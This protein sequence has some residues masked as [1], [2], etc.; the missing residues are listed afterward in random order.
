M[1]KWEGQTNQPTKKD[2][3]SMQTTT[4][5]NLDQQYRFPLPG[6][7][8]QDTSPAAESSL[9]VSEGQDTSLPFGEGTESQACDSAGKR[10]NPGSGLELISE[11]LEIT[12]KYPIDKSSLDK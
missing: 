9:A 7:L 4:T 12:I 8:P 11:D 1:T 2:G 10:D 5:E 6:D 3:E